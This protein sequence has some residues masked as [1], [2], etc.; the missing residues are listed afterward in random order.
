MKR[1]EEFLKKT[2]EK[3]MF[4]FHFSQGKKSKFNKELVKTFLFPWQL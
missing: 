1:K 2:F 3:K 4:S